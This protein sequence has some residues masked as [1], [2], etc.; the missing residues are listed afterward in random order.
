[1][2]ELLELADTAQK[3]EKSLIMYEVMM[4]SA[5]RRIVLAVLIA[6]VLAIPA[7][8]QEFAAGEPIGALN[9]TGVW[10]PMSDNVT[11]YGSFHFSESCTFDRNKNLILDM[12]TGNRGDA[13]ENDG[14]V[15]LN[16]TGFL[17]DLIAWEDGGYGTSQSVFS[18]SARTCRPDGRGV[19]GG[20][21][22]RVGGAAVG[23]AEARLHGGDAAEVGA[24][25]AA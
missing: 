10:Q 15:S 4:H 13:T 21:R 11:V 9:E 17:G 8:G 5:S 24:A 3:A 1:M 12:N 14:F 6:V 2:V 25:G 23:G 19:P 20:P 7:A 18:G 22:L 16:R